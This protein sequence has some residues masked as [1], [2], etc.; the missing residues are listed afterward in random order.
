MIKKT[1]ISIVTVLV[2]FCLV[3]PLVFC[4]SI[5]EESIGEFNGFTGILIQDLYSGQILLS[6]NQDRLF[7]PA[8][9]IKIFTLLAGLEILGKEYQFPTFFYFSSPVPGEIHSSL[10][11][12]GS[13]DPTHSPERIREITQNLVNKYQIRQIAGDIILDDFLFQKEEFLGR[14]WMWD[15]QNPLIGALVI[16]G[17][18]T[19]DKHISYYNTMSLSWGEIF[20][21]E[22][23]RLGVKIKGSI[24]IDQIKED[25]SI[26][27][28]FYSD[29]LDNILRS[30]MKMSDNQSSEIIFRTLPLMV[31]PTQIS[32][33]ERSIEILSD[34]LYELLGIQ[35]GEDYLIVDGCGLSEYNLLTPTQVIEVISYLYHKYGQDILEF[36]ASTEERGTIR[37]R[38]SF[39]LWAKTGSLP[40][41]SGLAGI[42]PSKSGRNIVFCLMENNFRGEKNDPKLWENQIIEYIYENY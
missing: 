17:Y 30:M 13:G 1:K 40:S 36:F 21:R 41:A 16:K 14:G 26:K 22:L 29:N 35:W 42:F 2:I 31:S 32:T 27:A 9:L 23:L 15:D 12:R 38:F 39:P 11:I 28:I 33:I 25:V 5:V 7:T 8:S 34:L 37:N 18:S 4:Q 3:S 24:K 10:Y 19:K 6:H 20:Y